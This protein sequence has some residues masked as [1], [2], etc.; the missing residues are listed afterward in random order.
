MWHFYQCLKGQNIKYHKKGGK[1]QF[2]IG[3]LWLNL[4][5]LYVIP[6]D[7]FRIIS[8]LTNQV[9]ISNVLP[10]I[11]MPHMYKKRKV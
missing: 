5:I 6:L 2:H 1:K 4:G 10:Y 7:L 9:Y 11:K 8:I 3:Q